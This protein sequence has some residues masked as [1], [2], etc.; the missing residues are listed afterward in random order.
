MVFN[1]AAQTA[2]C[3]PRC[4]DTLLAAAMDLLE[5]KIGLE[6][7]KRTGAETRVGYS[8]NLEPRCENRLP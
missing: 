5:L 1:R 6:R 2:A 3:G 7:K 4:D 8:R